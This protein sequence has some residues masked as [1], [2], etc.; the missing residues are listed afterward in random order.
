MT[1]PSPK[2][3]PRRQTGGGS[4][5]ADGAISGHRI[6]ALVVGVSVLL[7]IVQNSE[8]AKLEWLFFEFS[9]P[10]WI[11]LLLTLVAGGLIAILV[12]RGWRGRNR[13]AGRASGSAG[14]EPN[15]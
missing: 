14:V 1:T 10:L 4:S 7:L 11:M 8:S 5:S 15:A 6:L 12:Q 2:P 9:A 3:D 13:P